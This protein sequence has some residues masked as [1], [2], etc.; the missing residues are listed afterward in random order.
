MQ[1]SKGYIMQIQNFSVNDGEGIRTTIFMSGCPLD[2]IWC[3]NPEHK[4]YRDADHLMT[5]ED[6]W[7]Q[8]SRMMPF[9][10]R[11][12]GGVT[13]SGGECTVQSDFLR[14]MANFF[15]DKGLSL[16]IETCLQFDFEEVRDIL[17]KMDLIFCDIKLAD[18]D[19]HKLYT[20]VSNDR[21]LE[22]L[23]NIATL[24]I[25]IVVRIP[26]IKGVN[27]DEENIRS[28]MKLVSQLAPGASM[29]LLPYH[30][31]GEDKYDE[32]GMVKPDDRT[33]DGVTMDIP[34][35]EELAELAACA[36]DYGIEMVSYK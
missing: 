5:L 32:L 23:R 10:R 25:P 2:C 4:V 17:E 12:G 19:K 3:C 36:S 26:V 35:D 11:G 29:E 9:F 20:G 28:T 6:V 16:S 8:V 7:A 14:D 31:F 13:F 1:N 21:I 34:T 33:P 24:G 30:R 18:S 15:Y 27:A 22:N